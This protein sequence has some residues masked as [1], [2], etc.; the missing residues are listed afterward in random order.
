ME[1]KDKTVNLKS[2]RIKLSPRSFQVLEYVVD[3][4]RVSTSSV[5]RYFRRLGVGETNA[6]V[7]DIL[8]KLYQAGCVQLVNN[9][10]IVGGKL[11][12]Y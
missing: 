12:A 7:E 4:P 8:N 9:L 11:E 2:K 5:L 10:W 3:H 6:E 1:M